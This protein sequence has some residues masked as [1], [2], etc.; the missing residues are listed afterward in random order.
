MFAGFSYTFPYKWCSKCTRAT[1]YVERSDKGNPFFNG[2]IVHIQMNRHR[3]SLTG[4]I[5]FNGYLLVSRDFQ[6]DQIHFSVN[7]T[8][9]NKPTIFHYNCL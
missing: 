3:L 4:P 6:F 1:E 5:D 8:I 9:N 7:V 2:A